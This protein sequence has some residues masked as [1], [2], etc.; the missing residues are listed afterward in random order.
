MG[1]LADAIRAAVFGKD[2]REKIAQGIEATEQLREDYDEQV[3]NVG[4]TNAEIVDARGGFDTLKNRLDNIGNASPKNVFPTLTALQNAFPSGDSGIYVVSADGKWYYWN[5]TIWSAGGQYQSTGIADNSI[6][7]VKLDRVYVENTES[8]EA[9]GPY[10]LL[11]DNSINQ[12]TSTD[13]YII[14]GRN[15]LYVPDG[16][17]STGNLHITILN[18]IWTV[19]TTGTATAGTLLT[20]TSSYP[21]MK[22][23]TGHYPYL[24]YKINRNVLGN[25][26]PFTLAI[27]NANNNNVF[28]SG[29]TAGAIQHTIPTYDSISKII[30][31]C[32]TALTLNEPIIIKPVINTML[33]SID[34]IPVWSTPILPVRYSESQSFNVNN[35]AYVYGEN[36]GI[37]TCRTVNGNILNEIKNDLQNIE[38]EMQ[39]NKNIVCIGDSLTG[40]FQYPNMLKLLV[41]NDYTIINNGIGGETS[42]TI[43]ARQGGMNMIVNDIVIPADTSTIQIANAGAGILTNDSYYNAFPLRQ[44]SV[45][46]RDGGVNPCYIAGIKGT[47]SKTQTSTTSNDVAYFFA[48]ETAGETVTINRPT[49]I[50]TDNILNR[51]DDY[52]NVMWIGTNGGWYNSNYV[53]DWNDIKS[54]LSGLVNQYKYM[55]TFGRMKRFIVLGL[56]HTDWDDSNRIKAERVMVEE[57]GRNYINLRKYLIDYGLQDANITPTED[58]NTRISQGKI[59]SSLMLD[60]V[61]LNTYGQQ[62]VANQVYKRMKELDYI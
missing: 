32:D 19:S 37:V 59:P 47:L 41:G 3:I 42:A 13:N 52:I 40:S 14:A 34:E 25:D 50:I 58:D 15:L 20:I 21:I 49:A 36:N 38:N 28:P 1:T 18:G 31:Y 11:G 29:K 7:P 8:T 22:T 30:V 27:R 5:E 6:T 17:Y 2:V 43:C 45:D 60:S 12:I 10:L 54:L 57:F 24:T 62:I 55:I 61:H 4:N 51:K 53:T 46:G 48:R 39:T 9:N 23:V 33:T 26:L 56:W 16:T 44:S 35:S